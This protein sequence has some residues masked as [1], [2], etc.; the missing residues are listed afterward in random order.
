[1]FDIQGVISFENWAKETRGFKALKSYFPAYKLPER[2]H[3]SPRNLRGLFE[4]KKF[5]FQQHQAE[6][7]LHLICLFLVT[8]NVKQ[9]MRPWTTDLRP[10]RTLPCWG[11]NTA[12]YCFLVLAFVFVHIERV[13]SSQLHYPRFLNVN[14]IETSVIMSCVLLVRNAIP[15][16]IAITVRTNTDNYM[17]LSEE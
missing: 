15:K 2:W 10:S 5:C 9:P 13:N 7:H 8:L 16:L 1:M 12:G 4:C 14:L 17:A 11:R 3:L 6:R